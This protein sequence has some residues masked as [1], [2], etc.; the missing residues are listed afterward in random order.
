M[1]YLKVFYD[2]TKSRGTNLDL[3]CSA[4]CEVAEIAPSHLFEAHKRARIEYTSAF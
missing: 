2:F 3:N 1:L 4:V